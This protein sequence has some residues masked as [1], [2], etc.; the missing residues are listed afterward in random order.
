MAFRIN[1]A[2]V[3]LIKCSLNSI[4]IWTCSFCSFLKKNTFSVFKSMP[5]TYPWGSANMLPSDIPKSTDTACSHTTLNM[6]NFTRNCWRHKTVILESRYSQKKADFTTIAVTSFPE[7]IFLV[8]VSPE[9][10]TRIQ[11]VLKFH[12]IYGKVRMKI[13]YHSH[14]L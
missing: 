13:P 5:L 6:P 12:G 11:K 9:Q 10:M 4:V 14:N 8:V 7:L 2:E 3:V 1:Y